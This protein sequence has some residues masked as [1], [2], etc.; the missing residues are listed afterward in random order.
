MSAERKPFRLPP[1]MPTQLYK[2]YA[3]RSPI[4]THFRAA[5]CAEVDCEAYVNG[6]QLRVEGLTPDLLYTAKHS[7]RKFKEVEVAKGETYL[8]FEAGQFCFA[9]ST[10]RKSLDRPEFYYTG[11]GDFRSFSIRKA[12]QFAK[13]EEWVDSF[14]H[15]LDKINTEI[16]RG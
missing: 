12:D 11:R 6:W 1:K 9:A 5:T 14:Q 10:H 16:Q 8:I 7:G 15:H 13:P 4:S 3:V 2:T